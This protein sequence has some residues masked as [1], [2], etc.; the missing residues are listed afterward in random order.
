MKCDP[1]KHHRRSIRLKDYDYSQSGAYVVTIC[2]HDK[3]F[4]FGQIVDGNMILNELGKIIHDEW[5]KTEQIRE[6]V[7][8]DEYIIMPNHLH[9]IIV[10]PC[11]RRDVLQYVPTNQFRSPSGNIG[12]IIRGFKSASTK[13]IN[14]MRET[15]KMPL[16]QSNYYEHVVRNDDDLND[17]R[18]YIINNPLKWDLDRENIVNIKT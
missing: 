12:S 4:L 8:I 13:R 3:Q 15:P 16:W 2:T 1:D 14:E 6:N 18:E 5:V 10:I 9:G 7:K 11:N 17:I